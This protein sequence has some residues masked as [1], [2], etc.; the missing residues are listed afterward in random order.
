MVFETTSYVSMSCAPFPRCMKARRSKGK[1]GSSTE[2][3]R[4]SVFHSFFSLQHP[5]FA[6]VRPCVGRMR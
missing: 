5:T 1:S 6:S 4:A 3:S 2:M